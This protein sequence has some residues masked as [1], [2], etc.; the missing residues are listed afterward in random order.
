LKI[1]SLLSQKRGSKH[2][3]AIQQEMQVYEIS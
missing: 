1:P 3:L 2:K